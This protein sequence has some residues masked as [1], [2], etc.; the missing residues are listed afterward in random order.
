MS[1][2]APRPSTR[3]LIRPPANRNPT[4]PSDRYHAPHPS[5]SVLLV[6]SPTSTKAVGDFAVAPELG[7][8]QR[9]EQPVRS[10]TVITAA[11]MRR[12]VDGN[13]LPGLAS[14]PAC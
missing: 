4:R 1:L 7:F 9:S 8:T 14:A 2:R 12:M 11:G 5:F 10:V 13:E 3:Q 6:S